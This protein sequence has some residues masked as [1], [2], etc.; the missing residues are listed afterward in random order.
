MKHVFSKKRAYLLL[1]AVAANLGVASAEDF[2]S[3]GIHYTTTTT[4]GSPSA[5]VIKGSD[6]YSGDVV[7]P[8]TVEFN[9]GTRKVTA[10]SAEA[11]NGCIHLK[12]VTIG[13]NVISI[14]FKAFYG[15]EELEEI[16]IPANVKR[17]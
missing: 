16:D 13:S 15:C 1:I 4:D 3:G 12:S 11:F 8:A 5:T 6:A 14:G 10:I 9:G 17:V 2:E 7:I